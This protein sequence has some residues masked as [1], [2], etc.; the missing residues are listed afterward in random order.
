MFPKIIFNICN[1]VIYTLLIYLIYK[2]INKDE[3]KPLY[4][5][6][7]HLAL[8]F[9]LPVFGQTCLWLTGSCNYTWTMVIILLLLLNYKNYKNVKTNILNV[10]LIFLLGI[11]AGWTNENTSFGSI[12]IIIGSLIYQKHFTK[13]KIQKWQISGLLGNIIGFLIMILAP[14]NFVRSNKFNENPSLILRLG[15]RIIN[16]TNGLVTF[17]LPLIIIIII[18]YSLN[19]YYNKKINYKFYLCVLGAFFTTYSMALSPTFPERAYFGVIVFFIMAAG[20]LI[21]NIDN[22]NKI[23]PLIVLDILLILSIIFIKDYANTF[24]D[25]HQLKVS[26]DYRISY[27]KEQKAQGNYEIQLEPLYSTN[28]KNPNYYYYDLQADK[29]TWPNTDVAKYFGL[30]SIE[31]IYK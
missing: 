17:C 11:F 15:K 27:I 1:S 2:Y 10:I 6:L 28:S 31:G 3:E 24:L 19:K 23:I 13:D 22:I 5:I 4:L 16:C 25:L 9:V 29:N 8:W 12:V 14:G 30:K 21:Q 26:W 18:F 20:I 7:I